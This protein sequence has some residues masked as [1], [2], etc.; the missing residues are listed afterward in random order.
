[1][2]YEIFESEFGMS[3]IS[4][5][6]P[7]YNSEAYLHRCLNS[8]IGQTFSDFDVVLVDD[9]SQDKS[10]D[11]CNEFERMDTRITAI[12]QKNSGPSIARNRGIEYAWQY[13]DSRYF[14]FVDSDDCLHHQC[15]EYML[16]SMKDSDATVSMCR[17]RYVSANEYFE[18][19]EDYEQ[20]FFEEITAENLMVSQNSA[21][22]YIWGKLY[23]KDCFST[24]RYPENISFG[25]DNLVTFKVL[26]ECDKVVYIEN[27]LYYYFYTSTGITKSPW[28]VESLDVFEGIQAQLDYYKK[29]D[30]EKAYYKELE[31]YIQQYAYQIHRIR[32]NKEN[33]I[34]NKPYLQ[35]MKHKMKKLLMENKEYKERES[36]YWFEALHPIKAKILRL[37]KNILIKTKV[38]LD[39]K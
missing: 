4:I 29:Y 10:F 22:N 8:I 34:N 17:H 15:L 2:Y 38:K 20:C 33:Y 21:F 27:V 23:S 11:I 24:L 19:D 14:M 31:L 9:G 37:T 30:Y 1:M 32:E 7:V 3:E 25:E 5:I 35:M 12:H 13:S 18:M 26:F 28:T 39:R 16:Q 6:I 36:M